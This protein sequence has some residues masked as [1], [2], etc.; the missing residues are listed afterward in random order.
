MTADS[1]M[2]TGG[3][4]APA[5]WPGSP[6]DW[7]GTRATLH[8][9][10][11]VVGKVRLAWA[12]RQCHWWNVPLYLTARGLT[13]SLIPY[14][15]GRS[16]DIELD[17][18][19]QE[20]VVRSSDGLEGRRPLAAEPVADFYNATMALLDTMGFATSIWP[21]PVEIPG[22][23]RFDLDDEHGEYDGAQAR[24][25]WLTLVAA[26]RVLEG[27]R[28]EFI[29]KS[30]PV[31][32]FWGALDLAVTR[33]SGRAAPA[34][35]GDVPNCGPH[36]MREAYSHEV[37]S[38]GFW[39]GPTGRGVFYSYAYPVPAAFQDAD[40]TAP[41]RWDDSLGEFLLDYEDVR[42]SPDPEATV[43]RFLRETYAA[44]AELADWDRAALERQ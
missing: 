33:F 38:C 26:Q 22:A 16:F 28:S 4:P 31:H 11:Q 23:T 13:T 18:I 37:S 32:V 9:W 8:L 1:L 19:D 17:F 24:Q 27:F 12:P 39:P 3:Q 43:L 35:S 30:S 7:E 44:A 40:V 2:T 42:S 20:L 14:P 25:F 36:V 41:G 5:A 6:D 10:T 15:S 34:Y 21:M 29:G